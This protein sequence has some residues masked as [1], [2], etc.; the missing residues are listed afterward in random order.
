MASSMPRHIAIIMDG[1]GRWAQQQQQPRA[2]GH[3]AGRSVARD[4]IKFAV[5]D[6][7]EYLSLFAFGQDNWR[8]P[9]FEVK[10]LMGLLQDSFDKFLQELH[11]QEIRLRFIGQIDTLS[12]SLQRKITQAEQLTSNN[13]R[14]QLQIALNYSGRWDLLQASKRLAADLAA[15]KAVLDDVSE[16]MLSGYLQTAPWP[17]P[18]LLIRTGGV[19]RLSNFMLWQLSYTECFFT[20][21]LWPEFTEKDWQAALEFYAAQDRRYGR[22]SAQVKPELAKEI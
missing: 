16:D 10:S 19:Q 1:N 12:K 5:A 3:R 22:T 4:C 13:K 2:Y 8:R 20:P 6:G 21:S 17:D 14:L 15:S 18:D 7:V 11:Q 9:R